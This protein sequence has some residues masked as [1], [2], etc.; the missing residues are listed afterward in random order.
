[1]ENDIEV[2]SETKIAEY[3]KFRV[4]M[5]E[6][7]ENNDKAVFDYADK[8]GSK[9]ARSHIFKL[10]KTKTAVDKV[11][12]SK[13]AAALAYGRMVDSQA[14]EIISEIEDMIDVHQ[15]PLK[16]IEEKEK[17]RVSRISIAINQ[18]EAYSQKSFAGMNSGSIECSIRE[19][20]LLKPDPSFDEFM[21]I[22]TIKYDDAMVIAKTALS[23]R[24]QYEKDQAELQKLKKEKEDKDRAERE[25]KIRVEAAQKATADA[26][27]KAKKEKEDAERQAQLKLEEE[28]SK[29]NEAIA[30]AEK[31]KADAEDAARKA[32]IEAKE[33]EARK[34]KRL[35]DEAEAREKNRSHRAKINNQSVGC[36]VECGLR[37]DDAK[38]VVT[39]I[40]KKSIANISIN[41]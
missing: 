32:A 4:Q 2:L 39:A 23:E 36:L 29:K 3:D 10:R 38:K 14:K 19:L 20:E 1:M 37:H 35:A 21:G 40:A 5:A 6:L 8:K 34:A 28:V 15:K 27:A 9:D 18:I 7:K 24:S 33:E 26:E 31:A 41:Y 12:Q 25:E 16:E 13:K 22:A 11:R 17:A 30:A